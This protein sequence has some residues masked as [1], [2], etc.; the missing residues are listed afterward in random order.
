[1]VELFPLIINI[2][3]WMLGTWP[4]CWFFLIW[5]SCAA[6]NSGGVY[7]LYVL[8]AFMFT[9]LWFFLI[10]FYFILYMFSSDN[11]SGGDILSAWSNAVTP[12]SNLFLLLLLNAKTWLGNKTWCSWCDFLQ[13]EIL[14]ECWSKQLLLVRFRTATWQHGWHTRLT[15]SHPQ[16]CFF[17]FV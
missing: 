14:V 11:A 15:S 9:V 4:T 8:L 7:Q 12:C 3:G 2:L 17:I 13:Y 6:W 16:M 1:M 5:L 10:F